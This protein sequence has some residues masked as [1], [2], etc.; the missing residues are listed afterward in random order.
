MRRHG[1]LE[2]YE[3]GT[4]S[5]MLALS[6]VFLAVYAVPVIDPQLPAAAAS[7][8]TAASYVIWLLFI[9]DYLIRVS[10]AE[11]RW[12]FLRGHVLDLVIV[13]VPILRPFRAL[14]IFSVSQALFLRNARQ[15]YLRAAQL[16]V[17][18]TGL[19]VFIAATAMLDTERDVPGSHITDFADAAWW[20]VTTVTT[21]GYGDAYPVTGTGRLIAASLMLIGIAL[22]GMVTATVAAWFVHLGQRLEQT[23]ESDVLVRLERKLTTIETELAELKRLPTG[24]PAIGES[25]QPQASQPARGRPDGDEPAPDLD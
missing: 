24:S 25:L 11:R 1:R 20:A 9:L 6:L 5:V 12:R 7:V 14:R 16:V 17:A 18:A 15:V 13:A 8:C 3:T 2:A 19:V 23:D 4:Q 21:V 10:L 22:L